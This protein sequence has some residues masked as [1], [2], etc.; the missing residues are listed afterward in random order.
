MIVDSSKNPV[1]ATALAMVPSIDLRLIHL[2]RDGRGVAWSGRKAFQKDEQSGIMANIKPRPIW[3]TAIEWSAVNLLSGWGRH[4]VD[5]G[6]SV[7]IRYED[8]MSNPVGTLN[9]VGRVMGCDLSG[10]A[11]AVSRGEAMEIGH[12]IAGNRLRTQGPVR[13]RHDTEWINRLS[14][15]DRRIFW[16]LAGW[17][18][19]RYEYTR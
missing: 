12:T 16:T 2:V 14:A 6:K 9:K 3:R 7:L 11:S 13:M 15:K 8:L 4:Q 19:R 17:L 1:R 5:S 10:V 18:M